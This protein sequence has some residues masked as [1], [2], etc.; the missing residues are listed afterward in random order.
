MQHVVVW[1][2]A[3]I[4]VGRLMYAGPVIAGPA[5]EV[6]MTVSMFVRDLNRRCFNGEL[7]AATI[8]RLEALPDR[9]D[10]RAFLERATTLMHRAG[11]PAQDSIRWARPIMLPR[12][13]GSGWTCETRMAP[14]KSVRPDKNRSDRRVGLVALDWALIDALS[15][16]ICF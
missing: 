11:M 1:Q 10:A 14:R 15:R 6:Q 13:S 5:K 2:F 8:E 7:A 16:G 3:G 4:A 9:E 12:L